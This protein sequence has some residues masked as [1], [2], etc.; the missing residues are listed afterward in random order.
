MRNRVPFPGGPVI[1]VTLSTASY[2]RGMARKS[3]TNSNTRDGGRWMSSD[4]RKLI[5]VS[6]RSSGEPPAGSAVGGGGKSL[7]RAR[8][9]RRQDDQSGKAGAES[10]HHPRRRPHVPL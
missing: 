8:V 4:I 9:V 10:V 6:D 3:A 7:C 5:A 1:A 2:H